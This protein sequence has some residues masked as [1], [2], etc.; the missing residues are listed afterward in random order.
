ME[1]FIRRHVTG[2]KMSSGTYRCLCATDRD[3]GNDD[4]YP[5]KEEVRE[6]DVLSNRFFRSKD[7]FWAGVRLKDV[8][9]ALL[10]SHPDTPW[11]RWFLG[12]GEG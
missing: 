2:R 1:D 6:R 3:D 8:C 7:S 5:H 4:E 9:G 12:P 11:R 10:K